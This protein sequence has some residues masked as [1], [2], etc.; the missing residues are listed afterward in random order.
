MR[1]ALPDRGVPTR[2]CSIR[3]IFSVVVKEA[4]RRVGQNS[5]RLSEERVEGQVKTLSRMAM[6]GTME[7]NIMGKET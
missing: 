4:V 1:P 2:E 7:Q 3:R 5:K 6:E